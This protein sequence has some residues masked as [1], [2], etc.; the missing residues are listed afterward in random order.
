MIFASQFSTNF[1]TYSLSQQSRPSTLPATPPPSSP[2]TQSSAN[3]QGKPS[4]T[5]SSKYIKML[6]FKLGII[7]TTQPIQVVMR[8][9]QNSL[10]EGSVFSIAQGFKH[11]VSQ[12]STPLKQ[13]SRLWS[14]TLPA[15]GK[16]GFKYSTYKT[17]ILSKTPDFF[18]NTFSNSW[19][20]GLN[21]ES[22]HMT[23]SS[24]KERAND[25]QTCHCNI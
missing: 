25:R 22:Q 6:T 9:Q 12:G 24:E 10:K 21:K 7:V 18:A 1:P 23:N 17:P 3:S 16:E 13:M 19:T 14:G 4:D 5:F 11:V 20:R 2:T 15:L 8:V